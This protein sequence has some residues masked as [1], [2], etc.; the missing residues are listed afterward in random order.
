MVLAREGN[1]YRVES[2]GTERTAILRAKALLGDRAVTGDLVRFDPATMDAPVLAIVAVEPRRSLLERRT[3]E[4]RGA[5]PVAANI[6][7]VVVVTASADPEPVLQLVDRLLV[8]GEANHLPCVVVVNKLDLASVTPIASHLSAAGYPVIGTAAKLGSGIDA[9]RATLHGKVSVLTGPSGAGK[10]SLLNAL[11]PGLGL[12]VGEISRKVRRGTHTTTTATMLP[13]GEGAYVVDT[14]GFS[15]VGVW[16]LTPAALGEQ[17]PEF[18]ARAND[19]RFGDCR[20]RNEPGCAVREAVAAG[21]IPAA[22]HASYL[23][24]LAELEA[25][26]AEWE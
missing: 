12:R 3:P 21:V 25:L 5:R 24:I 16:N 9:L 8:I 20:H 15:E 1:S 2:A 26:P 14:P 4:G 11:A 7:Q 22:R 18:R 19:C 6:D 23:A 10:S 17:F 13:I